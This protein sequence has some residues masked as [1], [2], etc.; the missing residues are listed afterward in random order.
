MKETVLTWEAPTE[1]HEQTKSVKQRVLTLDYDDSPNIE[2][3]HETVKDDDNPSINPSFNEEV[4]LILSPHTG[5]RAGNKRYGESDEITLSEWTTRPY[6]NPRKR[7]VHEVRFKIVDVG[8]HPNH[9]TVAVEQRQALP[10][11]ESEQDE[12]EIGTEY[13]TT[14]RSTFT[15]GKKPT[16]EDEHSEETRANNTSSTS[17]NIEAELEAKMPESLL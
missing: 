2:L 4:A 9:V 7:V 13:T 15:V 5:P 12:W 8:H 6:G 17:T 1:S 14:E 11:R 16:P 10:T 3:I